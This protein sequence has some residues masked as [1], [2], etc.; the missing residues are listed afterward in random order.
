MAR[1]CPAC[2]FD[3]DVDWLGDTELTL[4]ELLDEIPESLDLDMRGSTVWLGRCTDARC[5]SLSYWLRYPSDR[6][7]LVRLHR[8]VRQPPESGLADEEKRLYREAAAVASASPRAACALLR[9]LMESYLKR[10]MA[11]TGRS[12]NRQKL[13]R[14]IELAES[15]LGLSTTLRR[16]LSAVR[17][18]GNEAAH[19]IYGIGDDTSDETVNW[20]FAAIDQLVDEVHV[21]P[22]QWDQLQQ[23]RAPDRAP[24]EEP[25]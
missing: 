11:D 5:L 18:Q 13:H 21:K 10:H 7:V 3:A 20:L 19:D 22:Q 25:F 12:T 24:D 16:G 6:S 9:L 23:R 17:A 14:L 15:E 2:E 1:E 4:T 8:E